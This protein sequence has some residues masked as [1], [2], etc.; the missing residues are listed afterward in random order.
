MVLFTECVARRNLKKGNYSGSPA[1]NG[2]LQPNISAVGKFINLSTF[3]HLAVRV[4]FDLEWLCQLPVCA[5]SRI[6]SRRD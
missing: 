5:M 1:K 2:C 3:L 4:F 6:Q